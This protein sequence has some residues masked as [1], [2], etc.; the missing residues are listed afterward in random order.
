MITYT[1]KAQSGR[2]MIEMLGVLAIVGV[3]SAG[4]IAGYSMAMQSYKTTSLIEKI[5]LIA[6]RARTTYKGV[7][8]GVTQDT[9]VNAGKI[10]TND[11]ANPFGG[12]ITV[13]AS[14]SAAFTVTAGNVPAEACVDLVT[15]D[16]GSTGV[17]TS[18]AVKDGDTVKATYTTSPQAISSTLITNCNGVRTLVFTFK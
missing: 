15:S 9:L 4:G 18:V 10:S 11:Y 2:S 12:N 7:Y 1:K 6:Q 17:F 14:G 5:N 8:T 16:W 13:A 3:L